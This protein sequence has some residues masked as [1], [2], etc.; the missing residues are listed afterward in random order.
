MF[1]RVFEKESGRLL[2]FDLNAVKSS[3]KQVS[4]PTDKIKKEAGYRHPF[5]T[6]PTKWSNKLKQFVRKNQ[7]IV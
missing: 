4:F 6:T 3:I 5:S 7:R 1:K 2:Y